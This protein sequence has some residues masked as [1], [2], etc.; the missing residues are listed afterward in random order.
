MYH[1][2]FILQVYWATN[3]WHFPLLII[4]TVSPQTKATVMSLRA[5]DR[6]VSTSSR[7]NSSTTSPC[8]SCVP[9]FTS[10]QILSDHDLVFF[11]TASCKCC[12]I[13]RTTSTNV[14]NAAKYLRRRRWIACAHT[15]EK[16]SHTS[17]STL[18]AIMDTTSKSRETMIRSHSWRCPEL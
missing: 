1:E 2:Q 15:A 6:P 12:E 5:Y 3:I 8:S 7:H 11:E 10:E 13:S 18:A 16:H 14:L 17:H 9:G 4:C